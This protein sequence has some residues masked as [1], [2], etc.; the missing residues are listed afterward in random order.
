MED[1][2]SRHPYLPTAENICLLDLQKFFSQHRKQ[3]SSFG[4]ADPVHRTQTDETPIDYMQESNT[5]QQLFEMLNIDQERAVNKIIQAAN[6][7]T[8][9]RKTFFI[10]GPG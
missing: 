2:L 8:K 5:G 10:D 3:C 1:I 4:L 9:K 6:D 7:I